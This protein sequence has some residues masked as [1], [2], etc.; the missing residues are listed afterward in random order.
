M[1][2]ALIPFLH[3]PNLSLVVG[4]E[5]IQRLR[6]GHFV[7]A[8]RPSPCAGPAAAAA[9]LA[10]CLAHLGQAVPGLG[11]P[12]VEAAAAVGRGQARAVLCG[13]KLHVVRADAVA[14]DK[15]FLLL[16]PVHLAFLPLC[17]TL[18][19]GEIECGATRLLGE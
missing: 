17:D 1:A 5:F 18:V 4:A 16:V 6:R 3:L 10:L 8:E 15:L 11:L 9:R 12:L 14:F 7:V 19:A 13:H 2:I